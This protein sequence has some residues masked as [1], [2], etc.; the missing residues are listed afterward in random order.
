MHNA[1]EKDTV[2][3]VT[4]SISQ[5]EERT[6]LLCQS[7]LGE[8]A[9]NRK[10]QRSQFCVKLHVQETQQIQQILQLAVQYP[11]TTPLCFYMLEKKQYMLP[12]TIPGISCTEA[13]YHAM[14]Q[15]VPASCMGLIE[16]LGK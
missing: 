2:V 9:L 11:G 8:E 10:I 6:D 4:G 14:L 5:K 16:R 13:F 12:K 3:F 15:I 7:V 1:L